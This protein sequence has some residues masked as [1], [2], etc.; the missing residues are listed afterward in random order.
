MRNTT[1]V[2]LATAHELEPIANMSTSAKLIG[3]EFIKSI[4]HGEKTVSIEWAK[5]T[6]AWNRTLC[7]P[8]LQKEF[9][10]V[11]EANK[12]QLPAGTIKVA[13]KLVNM[14]ME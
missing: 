11:V 8:E 14:S 5:Q 3:S 13:M 9:A 4:S 1:L 2:L 7:A 6:T 12:S 10:T